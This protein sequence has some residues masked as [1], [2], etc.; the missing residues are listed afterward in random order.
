MCEKRPLARLWSGIEASSKAAWIPILIVG[1]LSLYYSC[2][3]YGIQHQADRPLV[4]TT[5]AQFT[6][7]DD[8]TYTLRV[9]FKNVGKEDAMGVTLKAGTLNSTTMAT[10]LLGVETIKRLRAALWTASTASFKD[11]PKDKL[12][13]GE[14]GDFEPDIAFFDVR[15]FNNDL[16]TES[17]TA[18]EQETLSSHFSCAK[19]EK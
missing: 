1:S 13:G 9:S 17:P 15:D 10:D 18:S 8:T 16:Q 12:Y 7:T 5:N 2:Q 11:I 4:R 3:N 14:H 19:L 6:R